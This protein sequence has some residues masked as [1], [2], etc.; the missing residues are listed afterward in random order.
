MMDG[1]FREGIALAHNGRGYGYIDIEG[2]A[3]VPYGKYIKTFSFSEGMG[4]V[5]NENGW[6]YVSYLVL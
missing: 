5:L 1:S 4:L 6:G 3:V 2:N